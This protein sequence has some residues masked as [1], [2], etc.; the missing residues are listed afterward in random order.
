MKNR[1]IPDNW[2]KDVDYKSYYKW[3]KSY[4]ADENHR[5]RTEYERGQKEGATWQPQCLSSI[6]PKGFGTSADGYLLPCCWCDHRG[7]GKEWPHK[8]SLL[9]A[10]YDEELKLQNNDSIDDI[11][12]SDQWQNFWKSLK[13]GPKGAPNNCLYYCYRK[14]EAH[15]TKWDK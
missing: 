15:R 7:L 12:L 9:L 2:P 8:H 11:L 6:E 5:V 13:S 3:N 1:N 14:K 4:S 10:L